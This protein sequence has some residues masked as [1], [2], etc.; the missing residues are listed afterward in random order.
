MTT[1]TQTKED[2]LAWIYLVNL[3]FYL[4]PI[5]VNEMQPWEITLSLMALVPFIYCYFWAYRSTTA[6]AYRPILAMIIIG[7]LVTPINTGSLSL[8]TFAGFFLGFFYPLRTAIVSLLGLMGLLSLLNASLNFDHYYWVIYGAGLIAGVGLFGVA[9]RKRVEHKCQQQKSQTEIQQLATMLE[10]ERIARDLHDIMGH[11]LSS[12][13]L[14]AELAEKLIANN[15]I[16]QARLQLTELNS[17]ARDSLS[18]IRQTV[19]GYKHKGLSA[20]VTQ[21]C[22]TLRDKGLSVSLIG[23]IPKLEPEL[24]TQLI[25]SLTEL[26][27]NIV[28]HSKGTRCELHFEQTAT[29]LR[30]AIT[31]DGCPSKIEQGNGLIGINERLAKFQGVLAWEL[32]DECQFTITLPAQG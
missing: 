5:F 4:I 2:K 20:S 21:L 19:S 11:S 23:N 22:Q 28:R 8:F 18:Q 14:K 17:I 3:V 1:S 12:I 9:E 10:R 32:D 25:L 7:V 13:S 27:S 6:N 24:E 26:C 31:D 16:E 15:D 29:Q 30:I